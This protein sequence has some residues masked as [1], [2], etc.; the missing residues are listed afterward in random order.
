MAAEHAVILCQQQQQQQN[1]QA[2]V[3]FWHVMATLAGIITMTV[4]DHPAAE[5]AI[6][7]DAIVWQIQTV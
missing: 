7:S 1:Q 3:N 2:I 4:Y 6:Y 5:T